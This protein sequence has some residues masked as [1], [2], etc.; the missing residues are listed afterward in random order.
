M[1]NVAQ[2]NESIMKQVDVVVSN[3]EHGKDKIIY[4]KCSNLNNKFFTYTLVEV[5]ADTDI[6]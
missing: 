5:V 4:K 1:T 6:S 3:I 2:F